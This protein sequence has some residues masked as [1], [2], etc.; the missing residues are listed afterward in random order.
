MSG[1]ARERALLPTAQV[2][3]PGSNAPQRILKKRSLCSWLRLDFYAAL[4]A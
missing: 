2:S 3:A 1:P 4:L